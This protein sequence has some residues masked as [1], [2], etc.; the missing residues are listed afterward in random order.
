M[1]PATISRVDELR[2]FE[3]RARRLNVDNENEFRTFISDA[4]V[5]LEMSEANMADALSVSRP[6]FNRWVNG[7]STPHPLMRPS[8]VS[9]IL[10]RVTEKIKIYSSSSRQGSS[11]YSGSGGMVAKSYG[12]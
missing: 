11:S 2:G 9:R 12:K 7:R 3:E 5:I 6:T 4:R 1:S 8:V 10:S